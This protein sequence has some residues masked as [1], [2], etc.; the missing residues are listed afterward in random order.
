VPQLWQKDRL[1]ELSTTSL[2]LGINPNTAPAEVLATLPGVT[3][4][5]AK[6]IIAQRKQTPFTHEGQIIQI[7]SVPLN[8]SI[9]AGIIV[10]PSDTVRITQ[11][12][13]GLPWALQYAIKL[14]PNNTDAP[15]HIDYYNR[16]SINPSVSTN[17]EALELPPRSTVAPDKIP[18]FLL[19]N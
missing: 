3:E 18:S 4:E 6:I 14:T 15:W 7:T 9:G 1:I 2:S 8:F 16:V 10:I 13:P 12:S 5:I 17:T 19:P 11:S